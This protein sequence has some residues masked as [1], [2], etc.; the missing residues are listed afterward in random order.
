[1][2]KILVC[3]DEKSIL[4][5]LKMLLEKEKYEVIC[6]ENGKE[7]IEV[8]KNQILDLIILDV[9]L[10][11]ESGFDILKKISPMYKIPIIMLTAKND[12]IDKVL[13]LEFGADDYITKPFDT[14]E[15][16]AR[17]KAL[18]RRMEEVKVNKNIYSFGELTVN[19][20]QKIV[21]KKGK[22]VNLTPKEF[23][24]LKVLIEAKG[25]VLTRDELL[26]KVWG[27]DYYG[28]TRT[29][30]IHVLRL[31]KKIEDDTQRPTYIQT[32]FGFGYKFAIE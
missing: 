9:M 12:I 5:M 16:I 20:D 14:R 2:A 27:Y 22:I 15:L 17:V 10:P 28:D 26:D 1:M 6:V 30:D 31:R 3:D 19:F 29:V 21:K 24:L 25:S 7:V 4:N 18:L 32:V 13:G 23:D 8:L 11:D